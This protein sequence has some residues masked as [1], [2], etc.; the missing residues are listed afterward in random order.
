MNKKTIHH[1][2]FQSRKDAQRLAADILTTW[3]DCGSDRNEMVQNLTNWMMRNNFLD[4]P[5]SDFYDLD[6]KPHVLDSLTDSQLS[7]IVYGEQ[8]K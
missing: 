4:I 1:K 8:L 5:E 6:K 2:F 7:S 3:D